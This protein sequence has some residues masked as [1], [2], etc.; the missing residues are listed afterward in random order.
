MATV[1]L[2]HT[3]RGYT[4]NIPQVLEIRAFDMEIHRRFLRWLAQHLQVKQIL[5]DRGKK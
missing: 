5:K 4:A 3:S 1:S 2:K